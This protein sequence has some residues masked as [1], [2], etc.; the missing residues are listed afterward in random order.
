[1][2][3]WQVRLGLLLGLVLFIAPGCGSRQKKGE[4]QMFE[5]SSSGA[6]HLEGYGEWQIKV[7]TAGNLSISHNVRGDVTPYGPYS[8]LEQE[9]L[10]L[11]QRI[12]AIG[13]E[14][15]SPPQRAGMPDEV[16]YSF[17][18]DNESG[19][20][21]RVE[22]WINDARR[23]D[24]IVALVDQIGLLIEQYTGQTPVLK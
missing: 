15:M 16:Q 5:F 6:Y 9:N 22:I 18:L 7:D 20:V 23:N 11:W 24:K 4:T 21:H 19:R 8:L 12:D 13:L 17:S 10:A 2:Y 1:M 14:T 3:R